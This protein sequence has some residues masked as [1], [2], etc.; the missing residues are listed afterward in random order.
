[1]ALDWIKMRTDLY[2]DP[3]VIL[4]AESLLSSD[5][6]LARYVNQNLQRDMTVT[7]NVTRN[8]VVGALVAVWGVMRHQG[9]QQESD[10]FIA[11]IT[12]SVLNDISDLPGFGEAMESAGW[13]VQTDEGL[14]FPRFY[15]ENNTAPDRDSSSK[16][17]ERQRRFRESKRNV[18]RNVT[19]NAKSNAREEKRREEN[20]E[21]ETQAAAAAVTS[22]PECPYEKIVDSF[23]STFG[24]ASRLTEN[25]R[26]AIRTRWRDPAW[27][28]D[29]QSALARAGPSAFLRGANGTGWHITIDWF[30]NPNNFQKVI[31]GNY[32]N[33]PGT[34]AAGNRGSTR[35]DS[36]ADAAAFEARTITAAEY[37]DAS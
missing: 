21:I 32:D 16:N 34:S 6:H 28:R 35:V 14:V 23:N 25:R 24:T 1:M 3:K 31:E 20:I 27:R 37:L 15:E 2:R 30:L 4:M 9:K 8:A 17:A 7:R 36:A 10:L 12:V 13:V 5:G 33:R 19:S 29:W 22:V 11:D 26:K 18:T